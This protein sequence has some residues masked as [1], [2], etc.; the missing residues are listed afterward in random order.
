MAYSM[1]LEKISPDDRKY[2]Q[3]TLVLN[4]S[5]LFLVSDDGK[6]VN[7]PFAFAYEEFDKPPRK[8]GKIL[9]S[10]NFTGALRKEQTSVA[11]QTISRLTSKVPCSVIAYPPGFGKT[12]TAIY[13]A[14]QM[15]M[16]TLVVINRVI[17][18]QQWVNSIK[19]F[20]KETVVQFLKP[21]GK[22]NPRAHF[23]IV[24]AQNIGK[25]NRST[26]SD[27]GL[28]IVDELHQM[29]T[30]R[31]SELLLGITPSCLLGLSATPYRFDDYNRAIGW[32]FGKHVLKKSLSKTHNVSIVHSNFYPT[33]KY[34]LDG[35]ID[36]NA[37]LVSQSEDEPR[38]K[39]IVDTVMKWPT[40]KWLILVKRVNHVN[41]LKELFNNAGVPVE[42]LMQKQL[43]FDKTVNILIG[44][45]SKI[46][47]G[48]DHADIDSLV[49]AADVKNYFIQFLGRCM[50]RPNCV[51][52]VVD[53]ADNF[54]SVLKRH[55]DERIKVYEDHGGVITR[56]ET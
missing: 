25:F 49:V 37:V 20:A 19:M 53:I 10:M 1:L 47:V 45:T 48:F 8:E 29:I 23:V 4:D 16:K 39:M 9:S 22:I 56:L 43:T 44:T 15:R 13:I 12:I 52:L 33:I 40:R 38:N 42:T 5:S 51:P 26:F 32:F 17:L 18:V 14:C 31:Y 36:W 3:D 27:I 55:F 28:L 35:R 21:K 34:T 7:V 24:N 54:C 30:K 46:G 50:R 41:L 6:N 11:K 2:I